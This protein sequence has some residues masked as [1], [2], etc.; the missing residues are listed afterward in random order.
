M[1]DKCFH[2]IIPIP[3]MLFLMLVPDALFAG[4]LLVSESK[5]KGKPYESHTELLRFSDVFTHHLATQ[6]HSLGSL[7]ELQRPRPHLDLLH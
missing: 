6:Q 4:I 5:I 1:L 2:F 3:H 7:L